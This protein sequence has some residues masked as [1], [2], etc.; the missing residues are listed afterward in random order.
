M[1]LRT[2]FATAGLTAAIGLSLT[3]PSAQAQRGG[4]RGGFGAGGQGGPGNPMQMMM[5]GGGIVDPARSAKAVLVYRTDVQNALGLDLRQ[6]NALDALKEVQAQNGQ[7]MGQ[8]MRALFQ[9]LRGQAQTLTQEERQAK[10][11][12]LTDKA[13]EI[14]Q[15]YQDD[16]DKKID[17]ILTP[18][19][20][21]RLSEMDLRWRGPLAL[22]DPKV[23]EKATL[24]AEDKKKAEDAYKEYTDARQKLMQSMMPAGFRNRFGAGDAPNGANTPPPAP[25][26]PA[27]TLSPEEQQA[28]QKKA[29]KDFEKGRVAMGTKLVANVSPAAAAN[30]QG[31]IGA[32]FTFRDLE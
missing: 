17:E 22:V 27:P 11:Q 26:Q 6:K 18:K 10:M 13:K 20:R 1:K 25:A 9:G 30:W 15:G 7:K 3:V 12:E 32:P 21:R 31:M 19:Q 14:A 29:L 2:V 16:L 23:A 5:G 28:A 4:G 24:G 8:D